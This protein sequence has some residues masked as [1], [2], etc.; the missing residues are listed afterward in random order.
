[1]VFCGLGGVNGLYQVIGSVGKPVR[2]KAVRWFH[3]NR[4]SFSHRLLQTLITFI[5]IDFTWIFFRANR[6]LDA[7][8]IIREIVGAHNLW[9]FF[10]SSLYQ[11]GLSQRDFLLMLFSIG[12]LFM[13]DCLKYKGINVRE[14]IA[15]QDYWFRW[16][17]LS[18]SVLFILL[19]GIWG[20]GYDASSF[21]YFQF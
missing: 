3:L 16:G 10:D 14:V 6:F 4:D 19:V 7:I 1:M 8:A 9:I 15:R 5:L 11:C 20:I 2:N 13:A 21:L 18:F 17:V 12:I